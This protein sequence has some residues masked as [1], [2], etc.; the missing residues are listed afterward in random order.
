MEGPEA[1]WRTREEENSC[2]RVWGRDGGGGRG[3]RKGEGQREKFYERANG[4]TESSGRENR[5][6]TRDKE[7]NI[8]N[9]KT[10]MAKKEVRRRSGRMR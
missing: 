9:E 10:S 4:W 8:D 5:R 6:E 1:S 3:T 7:T 2:G